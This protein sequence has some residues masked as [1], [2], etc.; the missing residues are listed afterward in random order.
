[1][2]DHIERR[3]E[4]PEEKRAIIER[5]Y[6]MWLRHPQLRLGQLIANSITIDL[7]SIEDSDL[8]ACIEDD[9]GVHEEHQQ[10]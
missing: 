3:A 8:I 4:T 6:T 10:L 5:L 9:E 1:M 2:S 7:F